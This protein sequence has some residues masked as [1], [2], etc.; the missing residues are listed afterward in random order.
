MRTYPLE[1]DEQSGLFLWASWNFSAMPEL[2][3]MF[4]IPNGGHRNML[5]AK[6]MKAEGVK[7][8]VPDIFLPVA[9]QGFHGL[10]VEMKVQSA[11]PKNGGKGGLSDV[12]C[13]W[14]GEL[15]KQGFKVAVC[16]GRDEAI[17]EVVNYLN[18]KDMP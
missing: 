14:I 2:R 18:G 17:T 7:P 11:K 13:E 6:K 8:G 5:V 15:R 3:L 4:A 1:H 10:F 16:Y 9:R 12:Q